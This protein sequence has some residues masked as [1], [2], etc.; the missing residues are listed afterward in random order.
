MRIKDSQFA[1]YFLMHEI[2]LAPQVRREILN[3]QVEVHSTGE[4]DATVDRGNKIIIT[5]PSSVTRFLYHMLYATLSKIA[6][7]DVHRDKLGLGLLYMCRNYVYADFEPKEFKGPPVL[8]DFNKIHVVSVILH[9]LLEPIV[10]KVETRPIFFVPCK[11]TDVCRLVENYERIADVYNLPRFAIN[12]S[13]F[14]VFLVNTNV[15][16]CAAQYAHLL[17]KCLDTALGEEAARKVIKKVLLDRGSGLMEN[18]ILILKI[19]KGDPIFIL[20]FLD[21]MQANAQLNEEEMLLTAQMQC[22][23]MKKDSY[24]GRQIRTAADST[25]PQVQKQW[26]QWSMMMGLI[27]KQLSPMRGSMWPTTENM[28]PIDEYR[29]QLFRDKRKKKEKSNL[30]FEEMLEVARSMYDHN[31]VE[32]GKLIETMLKD[33]R[34]WKS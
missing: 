27:E 2:D 4:P 12:Q 26:S 28:K 20:D 29:R 21:Y 5:N 18:L 33:N 14:P 3:T 13:D 19:M 8:I 16:N 6:H 1:Q 30:N 22:E 15:H 7:T 32:P 9:E 17:T 10:G 24:L 34:A 31:A 25:T 23:T 11:F